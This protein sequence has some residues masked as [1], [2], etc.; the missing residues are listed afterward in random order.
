MNTY[1]K[2]GVNLNLYNNLIKNINLLIGKTNKKEEVISEECSF[3]ALFDFSVLNK[4]YD[5][6]VLVS[7]TDGV[8]T[9]LL[10][11]QEV[12]KHSNIG[13]DLVAMCVN[14]LLS[15]GATPLFFLDYF[16]TGTLNKDILLSVIHSII[17]GCKQ[18]NIA[19]VG[20]ET[21][22]MP[23]MYSSNH[24]DLAGFVVGIV[25]KN[26]ILPKYKVM[27]ENDYIVGLKS[28]G[29][30]SNGFSLVR[31]IFKDLGINYSDLCPWE[32]RPWSE[33]LLEP[34]KIYVDS[35]LPIMSKVKGIA[36][37]TG[38]GLLNNISRI[39]PEDLFADI[40]VDSWKWPDIFLWLI[41]EGGIEKKE[42]LKTFNCGIGM[43]L[44]VD[45][46]DIQSI[47]NHF[48]ERGEKIEIIGKSYK[49]H[50]SKFD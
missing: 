4:K 46:E 24:Y 29:I 25:D 40:K 48:E 49:K 36:H 10:I 27:R 8:G 17:E 45:P 38:G 43:V 28:N 37:I 50:K 13:I 42:M 7:S 31:H 11:A 33:I 3:S 16:A 47:K 5:H 1:I 20:G 18:A 35:L 2:S 34:T 44:I 30:H 26:N 15:Q 39:L 41:K 14:D 21:A 19:L 6:P 12:N 22:E 32:N 9:K 23:G